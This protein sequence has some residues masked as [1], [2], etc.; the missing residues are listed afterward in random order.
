MQ[1]LY[2][3]CEPFDPN[4]QVWRVLDLRMSSIISKIG[5][6]GPTHFAARSAAIKSIFNAQ[7]SAKQT[8]SSMIEMINKTS[9]EQKNVPYRMNQG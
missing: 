4:P 9:P 1:W 2:A 6:I 8:S 5:V 7:R 3:A